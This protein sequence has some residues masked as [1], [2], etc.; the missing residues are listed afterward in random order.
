V[1]CRK[2]WRQ[3]GQKELIENGPGLSLVFISIGL[4]V[5]FFNRFLFS[6]DMLLG[7]AGIDFVLGVLWWG[8]TQIPFYFRKSIH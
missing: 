3:A 4:V 7:L 1:K 6:H 8:W 5:F 2:C